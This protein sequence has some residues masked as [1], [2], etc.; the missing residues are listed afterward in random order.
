MGMS[1]RLAGRVAVVVL[2]LAGASEAA[3]DPISTANRRTDRGFDAW[4][5]T[6]TVV[7]TP[8]F[9]Q[10]AGAVRLSLRVMEGH[11]VGASCPSCRRAPNAR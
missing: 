10:G 3:A 2:L 7:G 6:L 9:S 5:G 11:P 4:F 8:A 1:I